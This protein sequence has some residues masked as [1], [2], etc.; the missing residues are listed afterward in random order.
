MGKREQ[1]R[2]TLRSLG[3]WEPY[4]LEH[5][6]L[7]GPRGNLELADAVADLGSEEQFLSFL[8]HDSM[9]APTNTPQEFLA[10]CGAVGLGE[11]VSQGRTDLLPRFR[12]AAS[13]E[14]WRM[15]E[16]VARG[17]QRWGRVDMEGLLGEMTGWA[18]GTLLERRAA[19]AA[20][21]EPSLLG[22]ET[23][24]RRVLLMLNEITAG[25]LDE[26]DRRCDAFRV[27]RKALGY[28]W[29]VAVVALPQV[30][31]ELMAKWFPCEDRDVRW[32]MKENLRKAR[33][34]RMDGAWVTLWKQRLGR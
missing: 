20:L 7:P 19:V 11:L 18:G 4:L 16:A 15:R 31:R 33:L 23:Q 1:Y 12:E 32:V 30:G 25:L 22:D 21:C 14:R 34:A 26:T 8:R 2:E 13:D 24:A 6:G 3:N 29:S 5:S 10:F 28:C 27:L 17:L 9:V